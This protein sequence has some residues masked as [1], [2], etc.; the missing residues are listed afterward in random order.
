[1]EVGMNT[2]VVEV[3]APFRTQ[4]GMVYEGVCRMIA[5]GEVKPGESLSLRRA[6]ERLGVSPGPARD[7]FRV[8][9]ERGVLEKVPKHGYR[10]CELTR[11][12][13]DGYFNVRRALLA[14][15]AVLAAQRITPADVRALRDLAARL[16]A[17]VEMGRYDQ[18]YR[19]EE[20]FHTALARIARCKPLEREIA[21][22]Q[23]FA[24]VIPSP[25][26]RHWESHA[27]LLEEIASRDPERAW[28]AMRAHVDEGRRCTLEG[29]ATAMRGGD[30]ETDKDGKG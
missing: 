10:V 20:R 1:M 13:V 18:A 8:L 21:R 15:S 29:L 7:A 27:R 24:I 9:H 17:L 25:H 19:P 12:R 11:E 5:T 3:S 30:A 6:A 26:P 2:S 14:E 23:T 16:D 4:T 22:I 28:H